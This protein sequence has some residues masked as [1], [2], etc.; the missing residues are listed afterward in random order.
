[1]DPESTFVFFVVK[2]NRINHKEHKEHKGEF[3]R[4]GAGPGLTFGAGSLGY[5]VQ[6]CGGARD[7]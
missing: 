1:M 5:E 3:G 6:T 2:K 7:G 4:G